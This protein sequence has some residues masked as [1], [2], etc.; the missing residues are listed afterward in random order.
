MEPTISVAVE[1]GGLV[2]SRH[3]VHAVRVKRSDGAED[4]SAM[5][6]ADLVTLTRSAAKPF[7]ALPLARE[8][9][10]LRDEEIAIACASHEAREEQLAVV[11]SL[12]A[13]A[14]A[15]E[16]DLECGP[17]DGSRLR[18]DC[19]GKHAAMLLRTRLR[20][21]SHEG[22]RRP[23]HPLQQELLALVAHAAEVAQADVATATDGCGVVAYGLPLRRIAAMFARL[24]TGELDGAER[25]VAAMR[26]HPELVGGPAAA[27][28]AVMRAV[29]G[30]VAK[31]GAEGVLGIALPDGTG[32]ALKV[33]DGATRATGPA[34][35]YV[36][37]IPE[38]ERSPLTNSRGERVG[39][40][41]VER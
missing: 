25:I 32:V 16:D 21:W 26:I 40:I 8:A 22:Y 7:Q 28:T 9:P 2:E 38:L 6:D 36:L 1:R 37:G 31:R 18:H 27:D 14:G 19:S 20:G 13:R 23:E 39:T 10:D 3:R 35:G 12:L 34:A 33:E 15:S 17:Q 30:A 4:S 41:A 5:G 11:R 29:P 24:A